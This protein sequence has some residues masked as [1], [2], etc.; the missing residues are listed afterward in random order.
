MSTRNA[1]SDSEDLFK[2]KTAVE[3]R[4]LP[5][6]LFFEGRKKVVGRDAQMSLADYPSLPG[7]R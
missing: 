4:V 2:P 3:M 6:L 1:T 7:R 5:K